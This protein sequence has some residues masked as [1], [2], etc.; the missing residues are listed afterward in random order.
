[1]T[2]SDERFQEAVQR[3]DAANSQD[4]NHEQ[5]G[6][7]DWPRELIYAER[8]TR[9]VLQLNPNASEALQLAARSQHIL[10]WK[11]P[12]DTYPAS[13]AGY[14]KWRE[15]LK[16]FHAQTAGEIL[17]ESGYGEDMVERVRAMNLKT[18]IKSDPD[19]QTLEDA[20]CLVFL[21]FQ[22]SD[23]IGKTAE[24][25]VVNAVRKSWGKMSETGRARALELQFTVQERSIILKA[26]APATGEDSVSAP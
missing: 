16:K 9:W 10:R 13:R 20:L 5:A 2:S 21:Q 23:L 11:I 6:D 7:R 15:D 26:L 24:D 3:M 4:P 8:L 14:L 19:T 25:K 12:R 17:K 22:L 18:N 1:M